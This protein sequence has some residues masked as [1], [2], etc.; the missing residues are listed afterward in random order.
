MPAIRSV[1]PRT[2]RAGAVSAQVIFLPPRPTSY[3]E[4]R[5]HQLMQD[6]INSQRARI[7]NWCRDKSPYEI[8][9]AFIAWRKS[10]RSKIR[11]EKNDL[12]DY[13]EEF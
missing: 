9:Q 5:K 8:A 2:K 4:A 12:P 3:E 7:H 10:F 11:L 13:G 1:S 6:E